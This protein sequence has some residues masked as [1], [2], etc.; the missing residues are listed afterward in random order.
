MPGNAPGHAIPYFFFEAWRFLRFFK[1]GCKLLEIGE[2]LFGRHDGFSALVGTG[3]V[4]GDEA[5]FLQ[6]RELAMHGG[7][8]ARHGTRPW[9][10]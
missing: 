10:R 5:L 2:R 9:S 6:T 1:A 4:E 8:G 7:R 3:F